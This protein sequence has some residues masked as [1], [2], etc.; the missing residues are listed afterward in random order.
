MER[1]R[2]LGAEVATAVRLVADGTVLAAG[3]AALAR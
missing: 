3:R 2:E 1:D